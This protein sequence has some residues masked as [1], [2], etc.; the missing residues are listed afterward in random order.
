MVMNG[1]PVSRRRYWC[2]ALIG[3]LLVAFG[4]VSAAD[5]QLAVAVVEEGQ[6]KTEKAD[7]NYGKDTAKPSRQ[8]SSPI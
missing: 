1:T 3:V 2:I 6:T 4:F 5:E 7:L 8:S